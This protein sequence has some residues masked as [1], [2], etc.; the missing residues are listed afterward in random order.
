MFVRMVLQEKN[1]ELLII[2]VIVVVV[3]L[4]LFLVQIT[5]NVIC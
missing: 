3:K 5:L 4:Q 2:V 1:S